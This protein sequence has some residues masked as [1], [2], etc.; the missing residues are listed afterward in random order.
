MMRDSSHLNNCGPVV[1]ARLWARKEVPTEFTHADGEVEPYHLAT[2]AKG[3]V[4]LWFPDD[5]GGSM[6]WPPETRRTM[7]AHLIA[8]ADR[9][10]F[11]ER[12]CAELEP[13]DG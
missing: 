11:L 13:D 9:L 2:W 12:R 10:E 4:T 8:M 5:D 6:S 7:A 1:S 3:Q